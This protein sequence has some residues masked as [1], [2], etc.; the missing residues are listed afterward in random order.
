M[1]R[2][3]KSSPAPSHEDLFTQHYDQLL[4]WSVQLTGHDRQ[5][6]EDLLHDVFIQFTLVQ[7]DLNEIASPEGYLFAMLRN[8]QRSQRRRDARGVDGPLSLVDYDSAEIGL[9]A[10][11]LPFQVQAKEELRLICHYACTRK[12]SSR[13]G[14][15]LIL[16]FFLGYYPGE[17]A[18]ILR[19]SRQAVA[20]LL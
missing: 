7:P 8:M 6:A 17:I 5:K 2:L 13:A 11:D 19:T 15:A 10:S 4:A 9:Q 20:D 18:Q 12:E 3:W 16:R 14:S 1:L